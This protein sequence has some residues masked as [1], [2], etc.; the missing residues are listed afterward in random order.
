MI[1]H[2]EVIYISVQVI[3]FKSISLAERALNIL[4]KHGYNGNI[5]RIPP[6]KGSSCGFAVYVEAPSEEVV[7]NILKIN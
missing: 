5:K 6:A 3:K 7:K 2:K 4:K 1:P